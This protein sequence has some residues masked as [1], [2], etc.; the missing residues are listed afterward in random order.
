[1]Q[2]TIV[3]TIALALAAIEQELIL[4]VT[5]NVNKNTEPVRAL[6]KMLLQ[7]IQLVVGK[8]YESEEERKRARLARHAVPLLPR[9]NGGQAARSRRDRRAP[10]SR[11]REAE[12]GCRTAAG[13]CGIA[14]AAAAVVVSANEID[15]SEVEDSERNGHGLPMRGL[16]CYCCEST[17]GV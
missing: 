11:R 12:R 15:E 3:F 4:F 8:R 14:P 9:L 16:A 2:K 5:L 10:A 1:M 7:N 13:C 6:G 17:G